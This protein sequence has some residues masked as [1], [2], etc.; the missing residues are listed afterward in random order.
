MPPAG[1]GNR[2]ELA[3]LS[4]AQHLG[5]HSLKIQ[6]SLPSPKKAAMPGR[7]GEPRV[8]A[9][10][11][12]HA[13]HGMVHTLDAGPDGGRRTPSHSTLGAMQ[14]QRSQ[15]TRGSPRSQRED[16]RDPKAA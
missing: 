14:G 7:E 6:S 8:Q 13:E 16:S 10:R 2:K 11:L 12:V 15:G 3:W 9:G 5:E 1:G 4:F